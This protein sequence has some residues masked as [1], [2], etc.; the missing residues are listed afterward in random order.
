M[1]GASGRGLTMR[2][3]RWNRRQFLGASLTGGAGLVL[4][5]GAGY[6]GYR[7]PRPSPAPSSV[8]T[9]PEEINSFVSRPDLQPPRMALTGRPVA[10]ERGTARYIFLAPKGYS[11]GGPGQQGLMIVDFEGHLVWFQPLSTFAMGLDVQDFQGQPHLTWWEGDIVSGYGKGVGVIAD[12]SYQRVAT[13]HA[14]NGLQADLH[15]FALTPQG[16][17]LITAYDAVEADLSSLGGPR[18]GQVLEGVVQEIDVATQRLLFEWRSLQHVPVEDTYQ[19]LQPSATAPFDYFHVNS[20]AVAPDGDL[21]I[22][23]RN[24]WSVYKVSRQTGEVVWR[25]GGKRST[26][27]FGPGA[28][29]YWQH[30]VRPHGPDHLSVFDNGASPAMEKQSRAIVLALDQTA[31]KVTLV[32]QYTHPAELL[33]PNQGSF[34][35]LPDG[36]AFVGWGAQPYVSQFAPN[37]EL[38]LDGRLPAD[39][40][41]YRAFLRDWVGRPSEAPALAVGSNA[42]GG[43]TVYVSWNG[44]TRV[45]AWQ[46]LAG[47]SPGTLEPVARAPRTGFE[48]AISVNS[49]GPYFAALALDR[50]GAE[51]GRSRPQ[52]A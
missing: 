28:R 1:S 17:A 41:S 25:L 51:L 20:V 15:E 32:R 19:K 10:R 46:I 4:L 24:T 22:S 47:K 43:S 31:A 11:T 48:T 33:V 7:W 26:F 50:A 49:S 8:P 30:H 9:S 6:V 14:Q 16:T 29:F 23:S 5:A 44:A 12:S 2:P 42:V 39:D 52:R 13:V 40:Q 3:T 37:G 36:G 18:K 35:V 38:M 27:G 45:A 34:E 21:L